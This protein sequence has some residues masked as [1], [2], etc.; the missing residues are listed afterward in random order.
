MVAVVPV[1]PNHTG[2]SHEEIQ[3]RPERGQPPAAFQRK[4]L[5]GP[6]LPQALEDAGSREV[7][8]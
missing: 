7:Q 5:G 6:T 1:P 2:R 3:A 4:I 8:Q